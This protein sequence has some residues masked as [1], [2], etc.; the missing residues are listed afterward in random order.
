MNLE[1]LQ[2]D[3]QK[4]LIEELKAKIAEIQANGELSAAEKARE[5]LKVNTELKAARTGLAEIEEADAVLASLE[6]GDEDEAGEEEAP[7]EEPA[8]PAEEPAA[9]IETEV[10]AGAEAPV[11][12][13]A[14]ASTE[15]DAS[16]EQTPAKPTFTLVA[17]ANMGSVPAGKV[18][19]ANDVVEQ[20]N[21]SSRMKEGRSRLFSVNRFSEGA[22]VL[23]MENSAI[24]NSRIIRDAQAKNQKPLALTA[25]ACFCGPDEVRPDFDAIGSRRRPVA[26]AFATVPVNGGF[27]YIKD[28]AIN[29]DSAS[30]QLWDCDDQDLVDPDDN[31]TWKQCSELDCFN[32]ITEHP[33]M[34]AACTIVN[35]THQW[36]HPDQVRVWLDKIEIEYARLAETALLDIIHANAVNPLTVGNAGNELEC[37]GVKAQVEYALASLSFSLGYQFRADALAGHIVIA[38]RGLIDAMVADEHIRGFDQNQRRSEIIA[39]FADYG[40]RLVERLDEATALK[41]GAT[42]TVTALNAGGGI[43]TLAEPLR[44]NPTTLYVLRPDQWL[45]AQGTLVSAD[46]HVDSALLRQNKMLYFY[47]NLEQLVNTGL[48]RAYR[49]DIYGLI[50]GGRSDL[51]TPPCAAVS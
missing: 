5:I 3:E 47:E 15:A 2:V 7:A 16:T 43:D 17:G 50:S 49:V 40:V 21:Y 30:V 48:E 46:W 26:D 27:R 44:Q 39:M 24:E 35:R 28:L 1:H 38:P 20:L 8:A 41:A 14:S 33:Y 51:V 36:A 23:S 32:E 10:P 6:A 34:I 19:D 9:P 18:L 31:T 13:A 42:A 45:H 37:Y 29:P 25:A 12:L 22:E 11:A 4:R